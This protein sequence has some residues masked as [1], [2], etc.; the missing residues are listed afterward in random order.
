[1][2][3]AHKGGSAQVPT[4]FLERIDY[5][6]AVC[7]LPE[8]VQSRLHTLRIWRNASEHGDAQRWRREGPRD[9]AELEEMLKGVDLLAERL[10]V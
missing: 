6:R 2:R 1:M 3:S 7:G 10:L 9:E 4:D 8:D 5:W